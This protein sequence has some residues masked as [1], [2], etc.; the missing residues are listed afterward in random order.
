MTT[1]RWKKLIKHVQEKVEDH[2]WS[3]DGLYGQYVSR[4]VIKCGGSDSEHDGG[5]AGDGGSEHNVTDD[6]E[7]SLDEYASND[8][9]DCRCSCDD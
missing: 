7:D 5:S 3:C 1:Y 4:F 9:D 8:E 2:Y 6:N